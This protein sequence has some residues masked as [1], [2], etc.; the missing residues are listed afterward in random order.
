MKKYNYILFDWD[1][2]LAKTL[3]LWLAA[4]KAT[5]A[6]YDIFPEDKA[7]CYEVFGDWDGPR[8]F[9]ITDIDAFTEKMKQKVG[10]EYTT[11]PLADGVK[12]LLNELKK[13]EK[14]LALLTTSKKELVYPALQ[15]HELSNFFEVVLTAEDVIH[16][17]PD[18]EIVE[19]A[20]KKLHGT[21]D[22]SI[23]IGDSRSDLGAA[24]NAGIDSILFY[25]KHN[26]LFYDLSVLN[27]YQPTYTVT[28]LTSLD[29]LR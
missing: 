15:Y 13:T 6:E 9:G 8:K 3:D 28:E 18:P 26:H 17:K 25:P 11:V 5:F 2:C 12:E 16:H 21:K 29:M 20:I 19:K 4:Y 23:I 27:Q 14:K 1:G 7:I 10:K 24:K 22:Q